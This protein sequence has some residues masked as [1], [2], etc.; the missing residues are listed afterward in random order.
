M[1]KRKRGADPDRKRRA[2][3][4]SYRA[5]EPGWHRPGRAPDRMQTGQGLMNGPPASGQ[6]ELTQIADGLRG[7]DP[8]FAR[9][10]AVREGMLRWAAPGRQSLLLLLALAGILAC[11]LLGW[12]QTLARW[13]AV[14][15]GAV[16]HPSPDDLLMIGAKA[17][18]GWSG[19]Q[20]PPGPGDL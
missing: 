15:A 2:P 3:G 9:Q 19:G 5:A 7:D 1:G 14:T 6:R 20:P 8:R 16:L 10:L 11:V 13:L 4:H 18:P 12:A 17:R